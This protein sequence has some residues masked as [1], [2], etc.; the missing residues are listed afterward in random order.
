MSQ[1]LS[2]VPINQ[3]HQRWLRDESLWENRGHHKKKT[4]PL[5]RSMSEDLFTLLL[6]VGVTLTKPLNATMEDMVR[7]LWLDAFFRS[8]FFHK[9]RKKTVSNPGL[10]YVATQR[11]LERWAT[12]Y[13][14]QTMNQGTDNEATELLHSK[15]RFEITHT[16]DSFMKRLWEFIKRLF[17]SIS[18]APE[19]YEE[20][21]QTKSS[22][23]RSKDQQGLGQGL[24]NVTIDEARINLDVAAVLGDVLDAERLSHSLGQK[25]PR[26]QANPLCLGHFLDRQLDIQGFAD[27]IGRMM[28]LANRTIR[29]RGIEND[30]EFGMS[31]DISAL[32]PSEM[33]LGAH[34]LGQE[35]FMD[36]YKKGV[37]WG[38]QTPEVPEKKRGSM[39]VLIDVSESITPGKERDEKALALGLYE[40]AKARKQDFHVILFSGIGERMVLR[41]TGDSRDED[42]KQLLLTAYFGHGTYYA[43]AIVHALEIFEDDLAQGGDMVLLTDGEFKSS[44]EFTNRITEDKKKLGFRLFGVLFSQ[45]NQPVLDDISDKVLKI[46]CLERDAAS[47]YQGVFE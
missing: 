5:M 3:E 26:W 14:N 39:V 43:E 1:R 23:V 11:A 32:L 33:A 15:E 6:F 21:I 4:D 30:I 7:F 8:A 28:S 38:I 44:V 29:E 12:F 46:Q 24:A 10:A 16:K 40:I 36:R 9:L 18:P 41:F 31:N 22:G 47:L 20:Q 35:L 27:Q 19:Q 13:R 45:E 2:N 37:L 42:I 25:R 34:S 17:V